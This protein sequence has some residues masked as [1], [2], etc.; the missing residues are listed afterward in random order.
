M[1]VVPSSNGPDES[2]DP[3]PVDDGLADI[4][5]NFRPVDEATSVSKD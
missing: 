1:I 5:A 3:I 2:L 4:I